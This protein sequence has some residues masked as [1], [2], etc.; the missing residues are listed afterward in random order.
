MT[1]RVYTTPTQSPSLFTTVQPPTP[2]QH[3]NF[4]LD[5]SL[6]NELSGGAE[7]DSDQ[8]QSTGSGE[9]SLL[10]DLEAA[11]EVPVAQS[12][13]LDLEEPPFLNSTDL[14]PTEVITTNLLNLNSFHTPSPSKSPPTSSPLVIGTEEN[15]IALETPSRT[16]PSSWNQEQNLLSLSSQTAA[17]FSNLLQ[18]GNQTSEYLCH[19]S[20]TSHTTPHVQEGS[21]QSMSTDQQ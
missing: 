11:K 7:S 4:D 15:L 5:S 13:L 3:A 17:P 12:D 8:T 20:E 16:A 21:L 2:F 18:R 10:V 1:A 14:Q 19:G 6:D 9:E